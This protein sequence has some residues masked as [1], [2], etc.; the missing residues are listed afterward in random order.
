MKMN[1]AVYDTRFFV[2][3]YYSNDERFL[4]KIRAEKAK[5]EKYVSAVVVHEIYNLALSREGR[6]VAKLKVNFLKQGFEV[7]SVDDQIAQISAELR[8]KYN[9]S[10]GDSMIAATAVLLKAVCISDDPHF[11]QIKEIETTWI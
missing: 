3:L 5:K 11:K 9:L 1:K 10:M 4:K 7:V 6:E 2:Q 8:H